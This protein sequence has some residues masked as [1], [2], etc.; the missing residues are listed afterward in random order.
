MIGSIKNKHLVLASK[1][2]RRNEL[3]NGLGLDFTVKTKEV[4]EDFPKDLEKTKVAQYLA[5]KKALA[6]QQE[7][8]NNDLLIT[9]DTVVIINGEILNKPKDKEEALQMLQQLSG[10]IHQVITGVCMMDKHKIVTFDDLTEVHFKKLDK[11]EIS[12][13]IDKYKPYDKAGAYGVQEWIGYVAVYK[14]VGSFYNVMGLPV[15]KIYEELKN[16]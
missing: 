8:G 12:N 11:E 15:H 6:F 16:W 3:M 7:L 5:E 10:N 13:Y 14:M 4:K 9:A 1:S 2:P